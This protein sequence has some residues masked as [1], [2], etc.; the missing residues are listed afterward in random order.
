MIIRT[1]RNTVAAAVVFTA[2]SG[3][4]SLGN[5]TLQEIEL[6]SVKVSYADLNLNRSEGQQTLYQRLR[7]A[8][9]EICGEVQSKSAREVR[10]KRDCFNDALDKAVQEV[11]NPGLIALHQG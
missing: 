1:T 11:G 5:A 10:Q 2:L 9:D 6:D 3:L 7:G 4:S 8:A